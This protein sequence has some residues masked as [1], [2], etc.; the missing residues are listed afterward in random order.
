M[1]RAQTSVEFV[2]PVQIQVCSTYFKG[3]QFITAGPFGAKQRTT[4]EISQESAS[5]TAVLK[6]SKL[7]LMQVC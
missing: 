7:M 3:G 1:L 6:E 2:C 5:A 4:W